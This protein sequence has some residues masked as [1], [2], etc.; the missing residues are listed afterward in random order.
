MTVKE[1]LIDN[2]VFIYELIGLFIMIGI[3]VHISDRIKKLTMWVIVLIAVETVVFRIERWT[4]TFATLSLLRPMMT[5][6]NYS[7]Y[8]VVLVLL[9]QITVPHTFSRKRLLLLLI[10]EFV[11]VPLFFTSQWTHLIFYFHDYN[12]YSSG[13]PGLQYLPYLLFGF[14]AVVMA[15]RNFKYFSKSTSS[16]RSVMAYIIFFPLIGVILYKALET[17]R[18]Y[19]ALFTS[20]IVLY[21]MYVY[22]HMSKIDPLTSLLNRQSYYKAIQSNSRSVTGVVSVDM[23]DLKYLNDNLGH[24]AGDNALQS[25]SEIMLECSGQ[26]GTPYRVGGDEFIIL[27]A[28]ASEAEIAQ[29][30]SDM[31]EKMEGTEYMCAFG[32]SMRQPGETIADSIRLSDGRMY[33]DKARMK[34]GRA[35]K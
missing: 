6:A 14:Y 17:D 34:A 5:A 35:Y 19:N 1:F 28:D 23:N 11:C 4:H 26:K 20:S 2:Y 21:Y 15:V 10:P 7:I 29:A 22:I 30:V 12:A 32:Y 13:V 3:G 24:E 33:E 9:M 25:V 18:D 8:P 31:R 27:Y 16:A